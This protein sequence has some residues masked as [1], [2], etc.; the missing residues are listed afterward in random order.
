M[1]EAD[2][3]VRVDA[4]L[5]RHLGISRARSRALALEGRLRVNGCAVAKAWVV[6]PGDVVEI[7]GDEHGAATPVAEPGSP[8]SIVHQ[9]EDFLV[10]DKPPGQP[11]HPL[12]D[13]EQGTLVNALLGHFP[14][15]AGVGYRIREA[16]ILHRLDNGTS[17]LMMVAR[18]PQ[19]FDAL[20]RSLQEGRWD[21]RYLALV[22]G[23]PSLGKYQGYLGSSRGHRARVEVFAA[24][25]RGATRLAVLEVL[26][27]KPLGGTHA[28]VEVSLSRAARHQIRA[29]LAALGHPIVGDSLYRGDV[30]KLESGAPLPHHILHA[31]YL[32]VP[33]PSSD[34]GMSFESG[35]PSYV[36]ALA[37]RLERGSGGGEPSST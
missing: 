25:R 6:A 36:D 3:G 24:P 1:T 8:L 21:K 16:G 29:Q 28:W 2:A 37:E 27:V 12:V 15:L 14:E 26:A 10:V 20:R 18:N 32:R 9:G 19:A 34:V 35:P 31:S 33:A 5:A 23:R 17:G 13:G 7:D 22:R 11:S 4:W 30:V